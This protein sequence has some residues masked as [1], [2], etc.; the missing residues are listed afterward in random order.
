M[1]ANV[2]VVRCAFWC[3]ENSGL[4]GSLNPPSP[5]PHSLNPP[6][7]HPPHPAPHWPFHSVWYPIKALKRSHKSSAFGHIVLVF[8][9]FF[10]VPLKKCLSTHTRLL[11]DKEKQMGE[12][13]PRVALSTKNKN[14]YTNHI[15]DHRWMFSG[16]SDLHRTAKNNVQGG[17]TSGNNANI[18]AI[19]ARQIWDN[20]LYWAPE[21]GMGPEQAAQPVE[22]AQW[23]FSG[24]KK[25]LTFPL[26]THSLVGS[27]TVTSQWAA[28]LWR[29]N[30]SQTTWHRTHLAFWWLASWLV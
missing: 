19:E 26:H 21:Q 9:Q 3:P 1:R 25:E 24:L 23:S 4:G 20:T 18:V 30:R 13:H 14:K 11:D 5:A 17:K 10:A 2:C 27:I 29:H 6:T 16:S 15:S 8:R 12:I 22:N 28:L 7:P